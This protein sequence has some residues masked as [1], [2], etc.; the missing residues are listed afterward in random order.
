MRAGAV[1][2]LF[3]KG[4]EV[5]VGAVEDKV[6]ASVHQEHEDDDA[7]AGKEVD[8]ETCSVRGKPAPCSY[9]LDKL[10]QYDDD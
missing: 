10:M 2:I 5:V 6:Q 7:P 8:E 9:A 1:G 3:V 4:H